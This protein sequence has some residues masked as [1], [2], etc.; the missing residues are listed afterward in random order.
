M[1]ALGKVRQSDFP[2]YDSTKNKP[3]WPDYARDVFS[4]LS[5]VDGGKPLAS[6]CKSFM[7]LYQETAQDNPMAPTWMKPGEEQHA[8][9]KGLDDAEDEAPSSE[10]RTVITPKGVTIKVPPRTIEEDEQSTSGPTISEEQPTLAEV[11]QDATVAR[12]DQD[13]YGVFRSAITGSLKTRCDC[14]T[15]TSFVMAFCAV[16]KAVEPSTC[17]HKSQVLRGLRELKYEQDPADYDSRA[18][19][20]IAAV[21]SSRVT[22]EDVIMDSVLHSFDDE[23]TRRDISK[24]IDAGDLTKETIYDELSRLTGVLSMAQPDEPPSRKGARARSKRTAAGAERAGNKGSED[25]T[26]DRC[27]RRGHKKKDC[28]AKT[29]VDGKQ[30]RDNPPAK[31]PQAPGQGS[32]DRGGKG[33]SN[34]EA[35]QQMMAALSGAAPSN[36]GRRA[37]RPS[38]RGRRNRRG[39]RE[40]TPDDEPADD[41]AG[42]PKIKT[43]T[44]E[45]LDQIAKAARAFEKDPD[46]ETAQQASMLLGVVHGLKQAARQPPPPPQTALLD[47]G[48][49]VHA[50]RDPDEV[51]PNDRTEV[52][53]FDGKTTWS[54]GIGHKLFRLTAV[55]D[56]RTVPIDLNEV[57][58]LP[59]PT[60]I[61]SLGKLVREGWGFVADGTDPNKIVV[62][63]TTPDGVD[64]NVNLTNEDVFEVDLAPTGRQQSSKTRSGGAAREPIRPPPAEPRRRRLGRAAAISNSVP[65]GGSLSELAKTLEHLISTIDNENSLHE[66]KGAKAK[67]LRPMRKI[68]SKAQLQEGH[69]NN[70]PAVP[71]AVVS[72][73]KPIP[74]SKLRSST[75]AL[76]HSMMAHASMQK[77]LQTLKVTKGI[78]VRRDQLEDFY[79]WA[80]EL[81]GAEKQRLHDQ[82]RSPAPQKPLRQLAIKAP[83][84]VAANPHGAIE[85]AEAPTKQLGLS[86]PEWEDTVLDEQI[87]HEVTKRAQARWG[88]AREDMR[89]H[90]F[91]AM[92]LVPYPSTQ[93]G[94]HRHALVLLEINSAGPFIAGRM[95]MKPSVVDHLEQF[96]VNNKL[97]A[98]RHRGYQATFFSDGDGVFQGGTA[99]PVATMLRKHDCIHDFIPPWTPDLNPVEAAYRHLARAARI[100][101]TAAAPTITK[102]G[103]DPDRYFAEALE[104]ASYTRL[105]LAGPQRIQGRTPYEYLRGHEP[106]ISHLRSFGMMGVLHTDKASGKRGKK[107]PVYHRGEPCMMLGYAHPWS[108][109]WR[110]EIGDKRH[111]IIARTIQISWD[112]SSHLTELTKWDLGG[113]ADGPTPV[114]DGIPIECITCPNPMPSL[115]EQP[116]AGEEPEPSG[117]MISLAERP[118]AGEEPALRGHQPELIEPC[119]VIIS[120]PSGP[121]QRYLDRKEAKAQERPASSLADTVTAQDNTGLGPYWQ[122]HRQPRKTLN[123]K[124]TEEPPT[125][126]DASEEQELAPANNA[127]HPSKEG[128]N[129][130]VV[131]ELAEVQEVVEAL[132][133]EPP[134]KDLEATLSRLAKHRRVGSATVQRDAVRQARLAQ[135]VRQNLL[136]SSAQKDMSWPRLLN[137]ERR[138]LAIEA[139]EKEKKALTDTILVEV[140]PGDSDWDQAIRLADQGRFICDE[141]RL[142]PGEAIGRHKVRGVKCREDRSKDGPDFSYYA[143]MAEIATFRQLVLRP[144]PRHTG[145]KRRRH[146]KRG[147]VDINVAFLQSNRYP[148][149]D[150][151][152][153]I[154]FKDPVTGGLLYYRQLGPIYGEAGAPIRWENTLV[155][156]L[157]SIGFERGC[158]EPCVFHHRTRD[159]VALTWVDDVY[160][161]GDAPD[162]DW[163]MDLM[164]QRWDCKDPDVLSSSTP[165][166]FVGIEVTED[167]DYTYISSDVYVKK[168]LKEYGDVDSRGATS[169]L[170]HDPSAEGDQTPADPTE[171]RAVRKWVG[172]L[173][174]LVVTTR[175]D[176]A[177]SH[178]RLSQM[179]SS[180]TQG[181]IRGIREVMKYL[182]Q[183]GRLAL[184]A[185]R[186]GEDNWNFWVDAGQAGNP[187]I[188]ERLRP[189]LGMISLNHDAAIA[190]KSTLD[191]TSFANPALAQAAK[192]NGG[193]VSRSTGE[194]ETYALST[195]LDLILHRSYV[196]EEAGM[197]P[198]PKPFQIHCD[199]TVAIAFS[200]GTSGRSRMKHIDQRQAWVRQLRDAELTKAIKVDTEDNL[201]DLFTK[202]L[203]GVSF[204]VL[205]DRFMTKLGSQ[206]QVNGSN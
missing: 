104:F 159:L 172:G 96:V 204:T 4:F 109:Q 127:I 132:L 116:T 14:V 186:H 26:C 200:G 126:Q 19:E 37:L 7:G 44:M 97:G 64:V 3:A 23:L 34:R 152:R 112:L 15:R 128:N 164:R 156:W 55:N 94:G 47:S 1:S 198:V 95:A 93:R 77:I 187:L 8:L 2:K 162:F 179:V 184:Y 206:D 163:F 161:D 113:M 182:H 11:L 88:Q 142:R 46:R 87:V 190:W 169:P 53:A 61:L 141:K 75:Y 145:S 62:E 91:Y 137:S 20:A 180:P 171:A 134:T 202:I 43:P 32:R 78:G 98:L 40:S 74:R 205:R 118:T 174:W 101:L 103:A 17:K 181:T 27:R 151:P 84:E 69:E 89:P 117:P 6:C 57:D 99:G 130:A 177:Y 138:E 41:T 67:P 82:R 107:I 123:S 176:L 197:E 56:G 10:A 73:T 114:I 160:A 68:Y 150:P 194:S 157:E 9:F 154:K 49:G 42:F 85:H 139:L 106:D 120:P 65:P 196:V 81:G 149:G 5:G 119:E 201:A 66:S 111:T 158:N 148:P 108:D 124:K 168:L 143:H 173:G 72:S 86:E 39:N 121:L 79:C 21:Y 135:A 80:C 38:R 136:L 18:R 129:L 60:P 166:D 92:D 102:S 100:S 167:D 54:G 192:T 90:E 28:F 83:E 36:N 31:P 16:H 70:S 199:A 193:H 188:D 147:A 63:L 59:V 51:N 48:A 30:L 122:T 191:S 125:L 131:P 185:P 105:R 29:D 45:Q 189:H 175:P 203:K 58:K 170:L 183:S 35:L 140:K 25:I 195:A 22:I 13:L 50:D 153:Y 155:P 33:G 110:V 71:K 12:L 76:L 52:E 165:I 146:R 133:D 115:A 178:C 24:K 144:S